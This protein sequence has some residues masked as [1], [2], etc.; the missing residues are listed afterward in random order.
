[1]RTEL[2]R[3][4]DPT[5]PDKNGY[6]ALHVAVQEA[7]TDVAAALISAGANVNAQDRHG[8]GPLWVAMYYAGLARA[9]DANFAILRAL[10]D[11]GA[12]PDQHNAVGKTPR[13]WLESSGARVAALFTELGKQH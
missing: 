5:A 10:L 3:G 1:V 11:A 7:H 9:S 8:N 4:A 6:T 2:A 12:D 13:S